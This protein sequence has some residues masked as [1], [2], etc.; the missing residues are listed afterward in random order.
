MGV[1]NDQYVFAE[2]NLID[3]VFKRIV[4]LR[5]EGRYIEDNRF[6]GKSRI[7]LRILF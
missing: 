7:L 6:G 2:I 5:S 4:C 1:F 3:K